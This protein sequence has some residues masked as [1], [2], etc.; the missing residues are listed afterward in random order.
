LHLVIVSN[1]WLRHYDN[2]S[3]D[4]TYYINDCGVTYNGLYL[5]PILLTNANL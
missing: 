2:T 5:E 4:F 3:N 1:L